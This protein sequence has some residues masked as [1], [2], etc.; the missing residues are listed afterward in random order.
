M[1]GPVRVA[2]VGCGFF[3]RNHLFRGRISPPR[4]SSWSPS[5][6]STRPSQGGGRGVSVPHWY[7]NVDQMLDS[8]K[9]DLI[10]IITRMDTHRM[11]VE[12]TI[13]RASRPS[14]RSRSRRPGTTPWP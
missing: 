7:S 2:I 8:E 11:M 5:A 14:S 3:A 10:D 6:T 13:G 4:A 12:K 1:A 9:I